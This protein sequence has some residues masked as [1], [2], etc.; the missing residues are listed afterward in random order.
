MDLKIGDFIRKK[1]NRYSSDLTIVSF[2]YNV[3]W[4]SDNSRKIWYIFPEEMHLFCKV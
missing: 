1:D 3:I 4:V 2:D